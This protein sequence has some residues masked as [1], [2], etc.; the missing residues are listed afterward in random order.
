MVNVTSCPLG[1]SGFECSFVIYLIPAF[2]I[3][4]AILFRKNIAND[5]LDMPFS[6]I[7]A[8]AGALIPYYVVYG[9]FHSFKFSLA[10]GIVGLLVGGFLAGHFL[11][12][13]EAE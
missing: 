7:G 4:G 13:G 1:T 9:L 6:I 11:P 12:D 3:M 8:G 2:F 5:V 10:A